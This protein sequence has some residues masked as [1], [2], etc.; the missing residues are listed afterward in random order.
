M[1]K[2]LLILSFLLITVFSNAQIQIDSVIVTNVQC[3]GGCDGSITVFTSGGTG[4][5]MFDIGGTPQ[6]SNIFTGLCGTLGGIS[7]TVTVSDATPSSAST[8]ISIT[9][10]PS[11]I[12]FASSTSST[13]G[14]SD[15]SAT[16]IVSGGTGAG[17]YS[18][19]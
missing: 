11:L 19:Q 4:T 13:C 8:N 14:N 16:A 1:K 12:V 18:Y 9:E 3:A 10:N 7:Y 17:T 5:E 15:G 2:L 6:T